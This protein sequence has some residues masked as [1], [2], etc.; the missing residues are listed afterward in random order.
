MI[1]QLKE[2]FPSD[3]DYQVSL[4]THAARHR[5]DEGDRRHAV[6]GHG[7]GDPG[8]LPVS[9][10]LARHAHPP[11]RGPGVAAGHV[12]DFLLGRSPQPIPRDAPAT[13]LPP[14]VPPGLPS[15]LLERR[16]DVREAE[17][18][19]VSA[20]AG[21]G[22]AKAS[23]FPTLS[24]TGFFGNVSPELGQIFSK[25]NVWKVD[26]TLLGPLFSAGRIKKN[27]EGAKARFEQAKVAYEASVTR[28]LAEVSSALVDRT[29]LVETQ[30]QRV[31]TVDAYQEAVRL[32]NLRY[33]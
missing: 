14:A 27:Y 11:D 28:S 6:A 18:V 2:R 21:I 3:L 32:A 7:A 30:R 20:N 5:R 22:V 25:G 15:A 29:K 1:A 26:S 17:Q 10:E 16:P 13:P 8:G 9:P 12:R 23:F 24:L 33:A 4:D 19:L 31:R